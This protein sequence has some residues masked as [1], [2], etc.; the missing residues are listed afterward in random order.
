MTT[1]LTAV[2]LALAAALPLAAQAPDAK[3]LKTRNV[4]L[5]TTDG[6]RPEE[7]FSGADETLISKEYGKVSN[8][9]ALRALYWRDNAAARREALFPF[10]W[11][12]VGK[13]GQVW[14]NR[15]RN[16]AVRVSNG[17]N[18]SY[19]GYSEF[20][21][22]APDATIDSNDKKLNVHT[23]VFEWLHGRPGY[24][25]RVAAV[26]NWDVLPWILNG[27][28]SRIP[29]WSAFDVPP[30]TVR[31]KVPES[32]DRLSSYGRTVWDGV[33]L[34]T[35]PAFA[36]SHAVRDL[37]PRALYVSFGETDDWAH[38]GAYDRYLR[39]AR[40]F[41][42]HLSDLWKLCQSLPQYRDKTTFVITVDHGRGPAPI[43]WKN[44]GREI[45]DSAHIWF[46][47][48][49]P[50]TAPL[51]ERQDTPLV[52]QSQVAATVAAFLGE[53]FPRGVARAAPPF[54]G[55]VGR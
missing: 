16:S 36:A 53:D 43:A 55:V 22:G 5:I 3:P 39:A 40:N 41:D 13:Q 27:P 32:L 10:L 25:G 19:P 23:N 54:P 12:T 28:R 52:T 11:G 44:H 14:G 45:A 2:L 26:V 7:V 8:T 15:E 48:I 20:L 29:I 47:V 35:F 31:L 50:D 38:E 1:R 33:T 4:F 49:G 21:T 34:D 18:F 24:K 42:S 46:A 9:N 51:G 17:Q 6:L 37:H 30:G